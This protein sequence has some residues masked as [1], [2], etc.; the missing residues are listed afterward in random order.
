[1]PGPCFPFS[2]LPPPPLPFR[3]ISWKQARTNQSYNASRH[4]YRGAVHERVPLQRS[5]KNDRVVRG[6]GHH[7]SY[8]IRFLGMGS[9][10]RPPWF[11][12]RPPDQL[13][14]S[15]RLISPRDYQGPYP[16]SAFGVSLTL[17]SLKK[18]KKKEEKR[19]KNKHKRVN[20][21]YIRGP[22][23]HSPRNGEKERLFRNAVLT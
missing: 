15:K 10:G 9:C 6:I 20:T 4:Q 12:F 21:D 3:R 19:R 1:M 8:H 2:F 13:G 11:D 5:L 23:G 18:H 16:I 7:R 14:R 22:I 17:T